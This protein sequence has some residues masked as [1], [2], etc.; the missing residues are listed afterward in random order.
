[1]APCN[2]EILLALIPVEIWA[3]VIDFVSFLGLISSGVMHLTERGSAS[4]KL[5]W[6]SWTT[7]HSLNLS[8]RDFHEIVSPVLF[9]SL[10]IRF[11]R[12]RRS[13]QIFNQDNTHKRLHELLVPD[14]IVNI[15]Q[16]VRLLTLSGHIG[17]T[18]YSH[19]ASLL[20]LVESLPSLE[21]IRCEP[22]A[23]TTVHTDQMQ[24]AQHRIPAAFI[25]H[26]QSKATTTSLLLRK[27]SPT[28]RPRRPIRRTFHQVSEHH[29]QIKPHEP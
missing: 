28:T 4:N 2:N 26:T 13:S 10:R 19:G 21:I 25:S 22:T 9:K 24:M 27:P 29:L 14:N 7:M 5:Q 8:C 6:E 18:A 3:L 11:P 12:E 15:H 16:H 1:M 20:K 23:I 17:S